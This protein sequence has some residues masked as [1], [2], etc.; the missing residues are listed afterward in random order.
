MKAY[1]IF[2]EHNGINSNKYYN[3]ELNGSTINVEY[4]RVGVTKQTAS[5]PSSHWDS[6][7][8]SKIK[9]GY[10]DITHLKN[11]VE[12]VV[13]ESDNKDFNDFYNVFS[14]YTGNFIR[15]NYSVEGCTKAQIEEAQSIINQLSLIDREDIFNSKLVELFKVI[16]RRMGN[17]K[18]YLLYNINN[19]NQIINREQSSL[20]SMDSMNIITSDNPFNT[21]DIDFQEINAPGIIQELIEN[22]NNTRYK[23]YKCFKILDKTNIGN[24]LNWLTKQDDPT[25]EHL[26]HGTR[27]TNIFNI[28]KSGLLIRPSNA[29]VIS[30][31]AYGE[32]IY[33]SAHTTKSM[34]YTGY[35]SDKIFF[36][37]NV[38]T[39]NRYTYSGWYRDGK[40]I[41]RH[42]MNYEYL[43]S[44]GYDSLYV[45]PGDGL[46]NSEYIVYN[47]EQSITDYLIWLK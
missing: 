2:V 39:G 30:G 15:S 36:I 43:K 21:L 17:V 13:K 38:H 35:D 20:D 14:K 29:A 19:K 1:L 18:E 31:A 24:H 8:R 32:G 6:L 28:L 26:I 10:T 42:Q 40:D 33:H 47:K 23:I 25:T 3:M 45:K 34:N 44:K 4:G 27:N 46:L 22:T 41:G 9:K 11:K 5:Y 37:Q 12:V 16:P 7:L